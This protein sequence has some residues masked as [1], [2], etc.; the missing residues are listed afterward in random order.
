MITESFEVNGYFYNNKDLKFRRFLEL[1][2]V[3]TKKTKNDLTVI[4]MNPGSSRPKYIDEDTNSNYL[5]K[6]VTTYPDPTQSQIMEVMINCNFE[7]AKI[8]NLSDIRN[9]KSASF[10]KQLESELKTYNHSVFFNEDFLEDYID[11][12][13]SFIFAWGVHYKLKEL[14]KIA[15]NK[16]EQL[17]GNDLKVYGLKH[18][19]NDSGYYHPLPKSKI[20]KEKWVRDITAQINKPV[21]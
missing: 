15:I 11:G 14:S 20:A 9:G 17:Y 3:G 18:P 4:M 16:I 1:K 10:Y 2:R 7:Y 12:E 6:F 8:I 21:K 5:D 13:S 19:K